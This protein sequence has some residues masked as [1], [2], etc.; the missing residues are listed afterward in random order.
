MAQSLISALQ[1]QWGVG[2]ITGIV[3]SLIVLGICFG[4]SKGLSLFR[5]SSE[6]Q[7]KQQV[8]AINDPICAIDIYARAMAWLVA[9]GVIVICFGIDVSIRW[10]K[11]NKTDDDW[12]LL[13]GSF[14]AQSVFSF[15]WGMSLGRILS[16]SRHRILEHE[17]NSD[18][19]NKK[20]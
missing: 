1:S 2:I 6:R 12:L 18:E 10:A 19:I 14:L 4:A 5:K 9:L 3:G 20:G 15:F 16:I 13:A 7:S 8:I 17:R 11:E